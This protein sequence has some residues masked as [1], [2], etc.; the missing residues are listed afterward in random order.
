MAYLKEDDPEHDG[1]C[2]HCGTS[3]DEADEPVPDDGNG[4]EFCCDACENAYEE[5]HGH[6]SDDEKNVCEF[7]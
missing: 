5:E 6:D 3:L 1:V 4:H 2:D 7:C